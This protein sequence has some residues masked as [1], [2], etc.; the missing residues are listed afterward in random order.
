M[1]NFK[2]LTVKGRFKMIKIEWFLVYAL[3]NKHLLFR[4]KNNAFVNRD[5]KV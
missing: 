2:T 1:I 5:L 3:I 4:F